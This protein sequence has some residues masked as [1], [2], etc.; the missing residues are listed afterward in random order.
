MCNRRGDKHLNNISVLVGK[1]FM[2]GV[3]RSIDK[4]HILIS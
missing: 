4:Y 3:V 2:V 1:N